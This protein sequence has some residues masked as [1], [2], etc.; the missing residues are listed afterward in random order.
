MK[1]PINHKVE[2]PFKK[3][4]VYFSSFAAVITVILSIPII[5]QISGNGPVLFIFILLLAVMGVVS[6]KL[7]FYALKKMEEAEKIEDLGVRKLFD[8]QFALLL[9]LS[10]VVLLSPLIAAVFFG[11]YFVFLGIAS[12]VAGFFSSEPF[13]YLYCKS[14]S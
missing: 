7:K 11:A 1:D 10:A 9:L 12:F 5:L 2:Y 4:M 13:L 3:V 6:F 8:R 14:K